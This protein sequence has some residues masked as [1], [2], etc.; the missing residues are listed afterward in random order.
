MKCATCR[1][2]IGSSDRRRRYC[3]DYCRANAPKK[4]RLRALG[5]NERPDEEAQPDPLAYRRLT[6]DV[7]AREGTDL[8]FLYAVRDRIAETV[9][10]V[11]CPPRELASLTRRLDEV[12]RQIAAERARI[13]EEAADAKNVAD[14]AWDEE[15]L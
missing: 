14:E 12:R 10:D 13:R 2:P 1:K 9:A 5:A 3:S 7:A 15:A 4:P 6:V 8:E 11:T